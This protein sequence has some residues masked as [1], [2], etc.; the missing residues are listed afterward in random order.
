MSYK[1]IYE[2][3]SKKY[4]E[5]LSGKIYRSITAAIE[6]LAEDPRPFGIVELKPYAN[7]YRIRKGDYRIVYEVKDDILLILVLDIGSR[8]QIYDNY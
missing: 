3:G 7:V 1:I 6:N 8:G 5:K 2:K 4:L